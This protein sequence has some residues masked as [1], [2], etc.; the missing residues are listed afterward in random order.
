M[1]DRAWALRTIE[2][3]G[4]HALIEAVANAF[5]TTPD[6]LRATGRDEAH[7]VVARQVS[8]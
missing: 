7:V 1:T 2:P 3:I 6:V 5:G 8:G 4:L